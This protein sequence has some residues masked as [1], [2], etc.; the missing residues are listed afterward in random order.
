MAAHG[1][2]LRKHPPEFRQAYEAVARVAV[3]T[4]HAQPERV[5][6]ELNAALSPKPGGLR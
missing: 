5:M 3:R 2:A 1:R 6:R 4:L